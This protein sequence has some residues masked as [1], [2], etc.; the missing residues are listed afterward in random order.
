MAHISSMAHISLKI[1]HSTFP[2][3]PG[4][5][6]GHDL[7]GHNSGAHAAADQLRQAGGRHVHPGLGLH[8]VQ[9]AGQANLPGIQVGEGGG[10]GIH[11]KILEMLETL[12]SRSRDFSR[13]ISLSIST[14]TLGVNSRSRPRLSES[15]LGL[16][17]E[18]RLSN[19]FRSR[20][21]LEDPQGE[22]HSVSIH[23]VPFFSQKCNFYSQK[24]H[25]C[26]SD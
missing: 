20:T 24:C 14:S 10:Q 12:D 15:T 16:A 18:S 2:A 22:H 1:P 7:P 3:P 5:L 13:F 11:W 21:S 23:K 9:C 4:Q 17:L 26:S 8:G 6:A 25:S 19:F